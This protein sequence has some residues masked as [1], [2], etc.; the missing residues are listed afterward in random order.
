[1][2]KDVSLV[3]HADT[4]DNTNGSSVVAVSHPTVE[5]ISAIK[6]GVVRVHAANGA[7]I[8]AEA[9]ENSTTL[10]HASVNA[11]YTYLGTV[12]NYYLVKVTN[13]AQTY[14]AYIDKSQATME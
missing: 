9:K 6:A 1:M 8:K 2:R 3:I 5:E 7:D 4:N 13:G 12:G 11:T 10:G 14:N